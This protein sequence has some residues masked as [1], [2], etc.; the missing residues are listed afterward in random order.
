MMRHAHHNQRGFT[1][2]EV[3]VAL[4]LLGIVSLTAFAIFTASFRSLLTGR[5]FSNEQ[6]NARVALE[7]MSRRLRM[8]GTGTPAGTTELITEADANAITF[9]ADVDGDGTAEWHRFCMDP[10]DGVIREVIDTAGAPSTVCTAAAGTSLTAR[11]M[12]PIRVVTLAFAYFRGDETPLPTLP[13]SALD[14]AL[15]RR[16]RI[17][18]STDSNRSTTSDPSDLTFTM[19]AVLRN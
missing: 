13:L 17:T 14:R 10:T 19:D 18:L 11:G 6:Q 3:L 2:L 8:A 9:R 16:I 5:D 15:V 7:W 12:R 4:S 1:M